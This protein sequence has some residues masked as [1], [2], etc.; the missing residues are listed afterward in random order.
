MKQS[1]ENH[2]HKMA[3]T[4]HDSDHDSDS[5]TIGHSPN[6]DLL[7]ELKMKSN[8]LLKASNLIQILQIEVETYIYR[9]ARS[10]T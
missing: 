4:H 6:A 5:D 1:P 2:I 9:S 3:T 7:T 10:W 8:A